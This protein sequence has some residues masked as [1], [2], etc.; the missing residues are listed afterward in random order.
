MKKITILSLFLMSLIQAN[1]QFSIRKSSTINNAVD[2]LYTPPAAGVGD[3]SISYFQFALQVPNPQGATLTSSWAP[4]TA[5]TEPLSNSK[6]YLFSTAVDGT[7]TTFAYS[8]NGAPTYVNTNF[9]ASEI[10]LGTVTFS[11]ANAAQGAIV[12]AVDIQTLDAHGY[13][14]GAS[15]AGNW[16]MTMDDPLVDITQYSNLFYSSPTTDE[17]T[18]GVDQKLFLKTSSPLPVIFSSFT[19][20]SVNCSALLKWTTESEF[21]NSY[22]VVAAST[23]GINFKDAVRVDSKNSSIGASYSASVP[24]KSGTNFYRIKAVDIDGKFK[25]TAIVNVKNTCDISTV[26]V[27]PNPV[28]GIA[29]VYGLTGTNTILVID[30]IGKQLG[31]YKTSNA[32][33]N[34]NM[35][36]FA[37]GMY[38]LQVT[39]AN[40][41]VTNIKVVKQ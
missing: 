40:G 23:D 21:N 1:A 9:P 20:T 25:N 27:Y 7:S 8:S 10:V 6:S 30:A 41:S 24:L 14:G 18:G 33:Q 38:T 29:K 28:T 32:N 34:I 5:D 11:S 3:H 39:A 22:Y 37:S 15:F 16:V 35:A 17:P 36:N 4:R 13:A 12:N 19:G 31:S 2:I 26:N